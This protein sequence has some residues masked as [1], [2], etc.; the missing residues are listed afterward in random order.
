[1]RESLEAWNRG[2][3]DAA[4]E[5]RHSRTRNAHVEA[6]TTVGHSLRVRQSSPVRRWPCRSCERVGAGELFQ[7]QTATS[8]RARPAAVATKRTTPREERR[9]LGTGDGVP[10]MTEHS[11]LLPVPLLGRHAYSRQLPSTWRRARLDNL[12]IGHQRSSRGVH[13]ASA[14]GSTERERVSL[15]PTAPFRL[16]RRAEAEEARRSRRSA[17]GRRRGSASAPS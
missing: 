7:P 8:K 5:W 3:R 2:D 11:V 13:G 1:M 6:A 16:S 9:S 14:T 12:G 15:R 4:F 10:L 17:P